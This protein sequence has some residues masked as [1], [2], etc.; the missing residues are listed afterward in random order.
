VSNIR[1]WLFRLL[2]IIAAG[3]M[4]LT[5]LQ[6]WYI[7]YAY[8]FFEVPNGVIIHPWGLELNLGEYVGYARGADMPGWF[9]PFMWSYLG[10]CL[11]ALLYSAFWGRKEIKIGKKTL[12]LSSLLIGLVGIS[13][14][15]AAILA[16][17]IA[18]IRTGDYFDMKLLQPSMI[19]VYP[20]V[21][22]KGDLMWGYYLI[23][24]FGILCILIA[25]LRKKI[26][27]ESK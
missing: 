17:I 1:V 27:G 13:Y 11:L 2:V 8:G 21:W 6:P 4:V 19:Q 25:L 22:V 12:T 20:E 7:A 24:G 23:Y 10:I 9:A 3:L 18:A 5:W 16:V 14:I 26:I 15:I